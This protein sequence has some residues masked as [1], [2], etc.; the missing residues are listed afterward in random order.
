MTSEL[1]QEFLY[2][3]KALSIPI[4]QEQFRVLPDRKFRWDF[5]WPEHKLAV[6]IQ[7][8]TWSGG[9][10]SRGWGIER[11]CEKHNL[12]V[13]AGWRTL[14]FTGSMVHSGVAATMLEKALK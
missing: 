8:G 9:A 11:D 10:H 6:E 3:V 12:A 14:L 1:E 2:H 5:A 7:G 13:L 4:P